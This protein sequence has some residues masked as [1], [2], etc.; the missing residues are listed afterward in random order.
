MAADWEF[1]DATVPIVAA[2]FDDATFSVTYSSHPATSGR[3]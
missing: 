1:D 3:R 2:F